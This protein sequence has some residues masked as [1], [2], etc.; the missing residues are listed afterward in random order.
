MAIVILVIHSIHFSA[1]TA[2]CHEFK[3]SCRVY[4][5]MDH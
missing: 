2:I 4:C 1:T 5:L 3:V